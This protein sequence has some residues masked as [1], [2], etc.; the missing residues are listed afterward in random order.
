MGKIVVGVDGSEG[1]KHAL[2]WALRQAKLTGDS[3]DIMTSWEIPTW[4]AAS[5][6]AGGV[7]PPIEYDFVGEAE[8]QLRETVA[9]VVGDKSGVTLRE[10]VLEGHPATA[11]VKASEDA[12]LLVVGSRG[13]GEFAGMLLGSVS[14]YVSTHATCPVVIMRSKAQ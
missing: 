11:L 7:E 14:M 6:V 4:A 5:S 2:E 1:S 3:L 9:E 10:V 13:H 12:D 8:R